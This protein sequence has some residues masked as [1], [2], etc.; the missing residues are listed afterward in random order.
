MKILLKFPVRGRV[1]KFIDVLNKYEETCNNPDNI[2]LI[3]SLDNDDTEYKIDDITRIC[4]VFRNTNVFRGP[5]KGKINACNR[6]MEHMDKDVSIIVLASDDMYPQVHGW[7]DI[8]IAEMNQ[9]FPDTDGILFHNDG[10]IG[11]QL[12]CMCILGRRYFERFNYIYHPSY[13]SLFCD[14][15][16]MDV[17]YILGKQVYFDLCLFKHEHYARN[18]KIPKD[19]LMVHNESFYKQDGVNYQLRKSRGFP[20]TE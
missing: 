4:S 3:V 20:I 19:S 15:E 5:S 2:Q 1:E 18:P 14:N 11:K 16:F 9:F 13:I 10:Y 8:L 17:G 12:N 7:D 6:D